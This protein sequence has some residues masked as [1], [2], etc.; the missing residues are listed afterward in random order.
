MEWSPPTKAGATCSVASCGGPCVMP[1]SS[2]AKDL[3]TPHLVESTI[4]TSLGE[5]YPELVDQER[6]GVD[7][8]GGGEEEA[9][10]SHPRLGPSVAG[11]GDRARGREPLSGSVA[12]KLHDT[13][14]FPIE[15]TT[16]IANERGVEVDR[17]GFDEEME[18]QRKRARNAWKGGDEA[19]RGALPQRSSTRPGRP[20]SSDMKSRPE[21]AGCC[22]SFAMG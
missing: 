13:F 8:L 3:I 11:R 5:A 7:P 2:R 4:D 18:S 16:E 20:C 22:R 12:F 6:H 14:G 21:P 9:V 1:G 19:G 15:L 10:P 17:S